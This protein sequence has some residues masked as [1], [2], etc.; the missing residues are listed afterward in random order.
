MVL[1]HPFACTE[2]VQ[3]PSGSQ[4]ARLI[5]QSVWF[6]GGCVTHK[7]EPGL[8]HRIIGRI[9]FMVTRKM[10]RIVTGIGEVNN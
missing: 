9:K 6:G 3:S 5:S 4:Q 8:P 10:L 7:E 2:I 1:L